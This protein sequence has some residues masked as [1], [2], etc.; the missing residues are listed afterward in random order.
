MKYRLTLLLAA[1][2]IALTMVVAPT[3]QAVTGAQWRAGNIISNSV[4]TNKNAMSVAE[5]QTF[6]NQKMGTGGYNSIPGQCDTFGTRNAAPYNSSITRAA[7]AISIGKPARWTCLNNYYEVPKTAPGPGIPANNYG[8]D[9]IPAGAKSAAQLIWDAA[10]QYNIS[11]KVLLV[12]IQKESSG[13]LTTDDWPWQ[14]QYT[15]AMGAHCPDSGPGGSANCDSNYAGFSIQ[16]AESAALLRWYLDNM[17]QPWWP[18][19]KLGNNSIQFHPNTAC[20][21]TTVNIESSATAAL[22]TYTPYQPNQAALNNLYGTGDGC[23]A[24]GNRNFWRI[25]NDWFGSTLRS[26]ITTIGEGVYQIENNFK[27]A[28][29]SE[30][31]FLSYGNKWQDILSV[32]NVEFNQTPTTTDMPYN[33]HYRDGILVRALSGGV[34]VVDNGTKRPF[35]NEG[36]FFSYGYKY[37]DALVITAVEVNLIPDGAALSYNVNLRNGYLITSA[38]GGVYVV[39]NGTKRPFPNEG[40]FFSYGYKYTDAL[41]ITASEVNIIPAGA[42]MP[43]NVNYRDGKLVTSTS[44]GVYK[45]ENGV[46]LAFP[47]EITFISNGNKWSD[48]NKITSSELALIPTGTPVSYNVHYRDGYLVTSPSGGVYVIDNGTKRPFPNEGTFFSYGYRYT[49]ALVISNIE[50]NLIPTGAAMPPRP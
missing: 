21:S 27:R 1:I 29:P 9:T 13:P 31:I 35:P 6:L 18:Y 45:I 48:V 50:L 26:L 38:L 46:K 44:G 42:T 34:Y 39:E 20:G 23:S 25:Y 30:L 10:Q 22:Y 2:S 7:Y 19:K 8:S 36:T 33:V 32:T 24:Y 28:Y 15:Y 17:T 41:V 37:T 43:F 16:I 5:V 14:N 40:T 49:D 47:N 11:P 3:A 12:T 4:F